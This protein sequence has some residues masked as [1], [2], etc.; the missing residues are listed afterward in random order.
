MPKVGVQPLYARYLSGLPW[1]G[2]FG[3]FASEAAGRVYL[4]P[5]DISHSVIVDRIVYQVGTVSNGNLR[6]GIYRVGSTADSPAGGALVVETASI[7]QAAGS[8]IEL[9]TIAATLLVP[10]QYF[11]AFQFDGSTAQFHEHYDPSL[12]V[13]AYYSRSGGYGAFTD[14][15]PAVTAHDRGVRA[16]LRVKTNLPL[17][18]HS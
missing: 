10:G 13:F 8:A 7:A 18:Y 12:A 2:D 16:L 11:L 17:G 15:C 3:P 9:L 14:P 1:L 6:G 5:I 4:C